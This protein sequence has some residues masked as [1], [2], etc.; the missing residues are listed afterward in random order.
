MK[1]EP[2]VSHG[3]LGLTARHIH[4]ARHALVPDRA[5]A[6]VA[7]G[8]AAAYV[9]DRDVAAA[10]V[11]DRHIALDLGDADLA[12][13]VVPDVHRADLFETHVAGAVGFNDDLA[14][15][16]LYFDVA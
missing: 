3:C 4:R 11:V 6:L 9:A 1:L 8:E 14:G 13:A 15:D 12:G 16:L 7:H 5:A 2:W 10:V